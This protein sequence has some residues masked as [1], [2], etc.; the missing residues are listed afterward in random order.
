MQHDEPCIFLTQNIWTYSFAHS[1]IYYSPPTK[2]QP[3]YIYTHT[4][5]NTKIHS[6]KKIKTR[7]NY[8]FIYAPQQINIISKYPQI[9]KP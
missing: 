4:E 9:I 2:K 5:H 3:I 7:Y 1:T 8:Y 6:L